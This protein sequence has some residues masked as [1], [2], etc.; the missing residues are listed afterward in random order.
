MAN[1]QGADN[2]DPRSRARREGARAWQC[3]RSSSPRTPTLRI[4]ADA[5]GLVAEDYDTEKV[6]ISDIYTGV[7][8][9][10]VTAAAID[11]FYSTG[12]LAL[13]QMKGIT[14]APNEFA[15]LRD[16]DNPQHSAMGKYRADKN[17]IV[18]LLRM[19]KEGVWGIRPRNKEQSFTIDLLLND[20]VK[21]VTRWS[22]KAGTGK[23]LMAIAAGLH[24][25]ME[26]SIYQK[27]LVS[28]PI[29]PPGRRHW[30]SSGR[31]SRRSSTPGCSPSSTTSSS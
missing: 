24:K 27:F 29:F 21:L 5:L 31:V 14:F 4:R 11:D 22:G 7:Q 15:L 19:P 17:K 25:T 18:A 6:E 13:D 28:R 1:L 26:E 12:E 23:T 2:P 20:E 8:E 16:R 3:R 9:L 10:P 30:L